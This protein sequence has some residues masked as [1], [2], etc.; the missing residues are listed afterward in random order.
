MYRVFHDSPVRY[1]VLKY[2][3]IYEKEKEKKWKG[4]IKFYIYRKCVLT[5]TVSSQ[6]KLL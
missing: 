1:F 3:E 6:N 4:K 2:Y 5:S